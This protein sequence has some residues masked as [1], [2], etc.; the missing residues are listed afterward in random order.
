MKI[1]TMYFFLMAFLFQALH[2]QENGKSGSPYFMI[3]GD[4]G[5]E[6]FPLLSTSVDVNITGPIA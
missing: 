5:V 3:Q 1:I 6:A 4:S 2:A